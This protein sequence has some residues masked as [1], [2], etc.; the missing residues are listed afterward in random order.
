MAAAVAALAATAPAKQAAKLVAAAAA[1]LELDSSTDGM[2]GRMARQ[3]QAAAASAA[4]TGPI[5]AP[6][7]LYV[8][9]GGFKMLGRP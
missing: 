7:V 8:D 9:R 6:S 3:Q 1:G 4:V 2:K 5:A